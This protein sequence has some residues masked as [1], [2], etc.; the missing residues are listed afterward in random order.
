MDSS[1][2]ADFEISV[3][4]QGIAK[5]AYRYIKFPICVDKIANTDGIIWFKR[6]GV[7]KVICY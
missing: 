6:F 5:V 4:L 7:T 3:A 2:P 1:S